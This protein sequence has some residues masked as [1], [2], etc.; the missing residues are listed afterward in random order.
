MFED[1]MH[2][3]TAPQGSIDYA[4]GAGIYI[5]IIVI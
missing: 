2:R 5:I 4:T 1:M 3:S